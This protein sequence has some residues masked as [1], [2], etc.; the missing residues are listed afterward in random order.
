MDS[1]SEEDACEGRGSCC[2]AMAR[3][4]RRSAV[5][6]A[7]NGLGALTAKEAGTS[8]G[9]AAPTPADLGGLWAAV[10]VKPCWLAAM[11]APWRVTAPRLG[12][13]GAD[14]PRDLPSRPPGVA[15]GRAGCADPSGVGW[16]GAGGREL[17]GLS[18]REGSVSG[19]S[20]GVK[21]VSRE[22]RGEA[23]GAR[24]GLGAVAEEG[25]GEGGRTWVH[26]RLMGVMAWPGSR[27]V[28]SATSK[29]RSRPGSCWRRSTQFETG[30]WVG[31]TAWLR[32]RCAAS[33]K[34]AAARSR[35]ERLGS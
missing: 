1:K 19:R 2:P 16:L 9:M 7:R 23:P 10:A 20:P 13:V 31:S 25:F 6:G 8:A 35:S 3:D 17:T 4:E 28:T 12:V 22:G 21:D 27:S 29:A 14:P 24:A 34:R 15:G 26:E 32:Y 11:A 5:P 33:V 18:I 30:L